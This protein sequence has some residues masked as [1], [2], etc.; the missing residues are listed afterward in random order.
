MFSSLVSPPTAAGPHR[1]CSERP[2]LRLYSPGEEALLLSW[3]EEQLTE[4]NI[5]AAK[6]V[7][8]ARRHDL[9]AKL[10]GINAQ[11]WPRGI[12]ALSKALARASVYREAGRL[13]EAHEGT[14]WAVLRLCFDRHSYGARKEAIEAIGDRNWRRHTWQLLRDIPSASTSLAEWGP[15]LR[16]VMDGFLRETGWPCQCDLA[17]TFPRSNNCVANEPVAS[18]V[19]LSGSDSGSTCKVIHQVKGESY[20]AAMVVCAPNK[21][22]RP[23]DLE[24]WLSPDVHGP[25]ERRTGYVALT[26]ARKLLVLA[27]PRGAQLANAHSAALKSAFDYVE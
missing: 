13:S 11:D 18:F 9:V 23:G 14:M 17:R 21:G 24:Q 1:A 20:D 3:F 8:L 16:G 5:D 25:A 19:R 27:I 4:R 6:A 22:R 15:A 7:A 26:R 2:I 10:R 12:S